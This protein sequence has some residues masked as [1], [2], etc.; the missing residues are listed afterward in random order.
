MTLFTRRFIKRMGIFSALLYVLNDVIVKITITGVKL[1]FETT[2]TPVY[3]TFILSA[4]IQ[5]GVIWWLAVIFTRDLRC[6][7]IFHFPESEYRFYTIYFL[8]YSVIPI[9]YAFYIY[10]Y[11]LPFYEEALREAINGVYVYQYEEAYFQKL[12]GQL[13]DIRDG[14]LAAEK[15]A[16]VIGCVIQ[17]VMLRLSMLKLIKVYQSPF[18][19]VKR[20]I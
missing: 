18:K 9:I 10:H 5:A 15:I 2:N 1:K 19:K 7:S 13:T 3:V 11:S 4:I 17:I 6:S 16:L 20:R 12:S 14:R 8:I